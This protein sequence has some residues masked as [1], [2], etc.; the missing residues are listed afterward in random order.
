MHQSSLTNAL[1]IAASAGVAVACGGSPSSTAG[2]VAFDSAGIAIVESARPQWNDESAWRLADNPSIRIGVVDGAPEYQLFH[3]S[4]SFG[5][6]DGRIIIANN[7]TSEIR[8]YDSEGRFLLKAGGRGGGPGEFRSMAW[9]QTVPGDS[10]AVF[11]TDGRVSLFDEF[12]VFAGTARL[13]TGGKA[14]PEFA[15]RFGDG[16]FLALSN[17]AVTVEEYA[18]QPIGVQ[19]ASLLVRRHDMGGNARDTLGTLLHSA[20]DRQIRQVPGKGS[21]PVSLPVWFTPPANV[22]TTPTGFFV[23]TGDTYEIAAFD[24]HGSLHRL[25]RRR[26]RSSTIERDDVERGIEYYRK[27]WGATPK[28]AYLQSQIDWLSETPTNGRFPPFGTTFLV[29][30]EQNLWVELFEPQRWYAG[31]TPGFPMRFDVFDPSGAWLGTVGMPDNFEPTDIGPDYV[32]GLW[33]NELDIQYALKYQLVK[34]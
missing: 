30:A 33:E 20:Y 22:A 4:G 8:Y 9:V 5:L 2:K 23:G 24:T 16:Q 19:R 18:D 7:G 28:G 3:A 21:G 25:I 11:E 32:L 6:S 29:D 15:A 14:G 10:V 1:A 13:K 26:W 12:G 27:T 34:P 17:P 31:L